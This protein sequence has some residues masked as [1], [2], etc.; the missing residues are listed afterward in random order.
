MFRN[1]LLLLVPRAVTKLFTLPL[2]V[3]IVGVDG[4]KKIL[5][6]MA[7]EGKLVK[8]L[9]LTWGPTWAKVA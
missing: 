1:F 7:M 9:G 8:L 5:V 2:G 3:G 6:G 4:T